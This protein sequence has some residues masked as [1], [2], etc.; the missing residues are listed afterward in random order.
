M[1]KTFGP[2]ED[3]SLQ[4]VKNYIQA[5]LHRQTTDFEVDTFK[6]H[7]MGE[8]KFPPMPDFDVPAVLCADHH[9]GYGMP[10]GGVIGFKSFVSPSAVGY[11]I[12]CGN[13]AAR[14]PLLAKDV[15]IPAV[16]REMSK[17]IS[18]G[19]GRANAEK[20]D[21][22]VFDQIDQSPVEG[23]RKLSQLARAQLGT[24]GS[25]NHYV[26]LFEEVGTGLLWVGV[27]F[28]SRGFG[29][30][31]ANGFLA[32]ARNKKFD[33]IVNDDEKGPKDATLLHTQTP[34]GQDYIQ[35]MTIAGNY[36]YAGRNWV[37]AKVLEIL[38]TSSNFEVHNHHNFAWLENG[39]WVHRKGA[40]PAFPGQYGFVGGSMGGTDLSVILRGVES[41]VSKAAL[42]STVHGA[43]RVM[44]RTQAAGKQIY[45]GWRCNRRECDYVAKANT[46][47]TTGTRDHGDHGPKCP[48]CGQGELY[49]AKRQMRLPG[50]KVNWNEVRQRLK[51]QGVH[52]IG[53]GADEAPEAYKRLDEVLGY[54]A[55]TV[56]IVH[57]LRPI[58]VIMAGDD[59]TDPYKD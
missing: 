42:Y 30:K 7:V 50:G 31:T 1:I 22:D 16:L 15:D 13:K 52:L 17:Q 58:G 44:S 28:G 59:V 3:A 20:I 53:G 11:D 9:K 5:A 56:D 47:N 34:L 26:D 49:F 18:F 39:L 27:H 23:Q 12:A 19:V 10:V 21:H 35:A 24:V 57:K 51:A 8:G 48:A 25:G 14:T 55:G 41:Q 2:V 6:F 4:Q 43:G 29:W 32:L 36:A 45:K 37:V 54:H 40:T 38:G 33:D 46:H